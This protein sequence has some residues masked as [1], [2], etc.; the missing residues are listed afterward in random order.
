MVEVNRQ[1]AWY[2]TRLGIA[3]LIV[4]PSIIIGIGLAVAL[5]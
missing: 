3:F 4:G 1:P 2:L 5:S